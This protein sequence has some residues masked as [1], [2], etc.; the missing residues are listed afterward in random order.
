MN[1]HFV[2][3]ILFMTTLIARAVEW[4]ALPSLPSG[5]G[6]FIAGAIG[7]DLILAGGISWKSDVKEWRDTILRFDATEKKWCEIGNLPQPLAY[8]SFG[9]TKKGLFFVGGSDGKTTSR[10]VQFL[11]QQMES[12]AIAELPQPLCY[13]AF[14]I[15]DHTLFVV[16]GGSDVND[17]KTLTNLFYSVDLKTGKATSLPAFPGGNLIVPTASIIGDQLYVFTGATFDSTNNRALNSD[18]A[19]AYSIAE[20]KWRRIKSYPFPVRGLAS[21]ALNDRYILLGGGYAENFTDAAFIYDT[22][23]DSYLQTELMPFVA[24]ANFIKVGG[25]IYWMGGEDKMRHRSDLAFR[26]RWKD[27]VRET[28]R[29]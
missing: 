25:F 18:A 10:K 9:Q 11:N 23:T 7:E 15:A 5:A 19:Y 28:K 3:T 6:N 13:S 20:K 21:C 29:K 4:E 26:I 27:L 24:A 8:A 12:Q 2:L 14:A 16:S 1:R 17:L 22:K